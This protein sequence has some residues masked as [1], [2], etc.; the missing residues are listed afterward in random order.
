MYPNNNL[1]FP[2]GTS[3]SAPIFGVCV[4]VCVWIIC[5]HKVPTSIFEMSS[6]DFTIP[7]KKGNRLHY[8]ELPA[9]IPGIPQ[10]L[11]N[12]YFCT[13]NKVLTGNNP[14]WYGISTDCKALQKEVNSAEYTI[15]GALP[16]LK[17]IYTRRS[18]NKAR[19]IIR[20]PRN[21]L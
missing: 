9:K 8:R 4:C 6:R 13:I 1:F 5:L 15:G 11:R 16:C 19:R 17:D 20:D 3:L 14:A 10:I 18:K 2:L 12:L 21:E 7:K